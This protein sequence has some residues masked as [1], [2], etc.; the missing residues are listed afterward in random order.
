VNDA[1]G[2]AG[3][4]TPATLLDAVPFAAALLSADGRVWYL[5]RHWPWGGG[6]LGRRYDAL[7]AERTSFPPS[8]VVSLSEAIAATL[9]GSGEEATIEFAE[10]G[11]AP[12]RWLRVRCAPVDG[13]GALML[14]ED[15]S[16]QRRR[17]LELALRADHD[18][19]T[20]L[21][22]RTRFLY[23]G[24]RM[25]AV[26]ER[27]GWGM[28][29]L[30][31][32][33][34]GFKD[35][36]DSAGHSFGDAVLQQVARRLAGRTRSGDLIA[37]IGGDEFVALL[38]DVNAE[39]ATLLAQRYRR[40]LQAPPIVPGAP[41]EISASVG[42]AWFPGA[43]KNL[44]TLLRLADAAMYRAKAEGSGVVSVSRAPVDGEAELETHG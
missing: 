25:L 30:F 33:L 6:A 17:E 31:L 18:P 10:V 24:E 22:N 36:N 1:E 35:I 11:E 3:V 41:L 8:V 39:T 42:V 9:D 15:V 34:D 2:R 13:G 20:K 26:A 5:N 27:Q 40:A 21:A 37:R 12:V 23:E 19:L 16:E 29:L 44:T 28:A 38:N 4:P 7:L 43:A 14:V 32:D